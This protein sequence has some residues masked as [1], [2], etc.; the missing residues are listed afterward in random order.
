MKAIFKATAVLGGASAIN[1]LIGLVSSKVTAVLLGP[2]GFGLMALYQSILTLTVMI[3]GLGVP[4]A[5]TRAMARAFA[6][7]SEQ[8][9]VDLRRASLVLTLG[10]AFLSMA[11]IAWFSQPITRSMLDGKTDLWWAAFVVPA[12][13]FSMLSGLQSAVINA[14]HRINDLARISVLTAALS[15]VPAVALTWVFR[16]HGVAPALA[17]NTLIGLGI[18]YYYYRK[19]ENKLEA[20]EKFSLASVSGPIRELLSFGVPYM[21]SLAVGA[22]IVAAL[23]ILVLHA[24]GP[25]EVGLYR[26]A[27]AIAVNYLGL[28]L[29]AMA[30]DY[31]PRIAKAPDDAQILH[32]IVNDQLRLVL[33]LAGPVI[34]GM[35]GAVPYLVPLLYS[36]KF[37]PAASLLEWQLIGDLFKFCTWT[38][39]FVIMVRLGSITFFITELL[40][41]LVLLASSW[42]G[43]K[44]WG[45]TGLGIGFLVTGVI[46]C[47]IN[48][49]VLYRSTK[50]TW[51][52]KN[53]MLFLMLA[54]GMALLRVI[55]MAE[56][57]LLNLA[58]AVIL[59]GGFGLYSL[60][61]ISNEFGGWRAIVARRR[62]AVSA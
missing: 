4:T 49:L 57:P 5:L 60:L 12:I 50:I 6:E 26:A 40:C 37:A 32:A 43:M 29:A 17:A 54:A 19:D 9:A 21:A 2:S 24:L 30:Q 25:A 1:I 33:L 15:L 35:M 55:A 56:R 23:P 52:L 44:I 38:M 36:G 3:A 18:G 42:A 46:A 39:G 48:W 28:I 41:G 10:A 22:G 11:L 47:A 31:F 14:R 16:E 34:L 20:V 61:M 59:A 51:D 27:S 58:S 13:L 7:V 45:L 62:G 8:R 53:I